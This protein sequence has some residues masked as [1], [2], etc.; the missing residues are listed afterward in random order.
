[1]IIICYQFEEPSI[2][3]ASWTLSNFGGCPKCL[4]WPSQSRPMT[5]SVRKS[6]PQTSNTRTSTKPYQYLWPEIHGSK[7]WWKIIR[8]PANQPASH[9]SCQP[10]AGHLARLPAGKPAGHQRITKSIYMKIAWYVQE[11]VEC[12]QISG[13]V[14]QV[15]CAHNPPPCHFFANCKLNIPGCNTF[16][17]TCCQEVLKTRMQKT[18]H[19]Q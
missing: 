15:R 17:K 12:E 6:R 3:P 16:F 7:S 9:T 10:P 2:E 1:M 19:S 14:I 5:D 13:N 11:S 18:S 4:K 8:Q